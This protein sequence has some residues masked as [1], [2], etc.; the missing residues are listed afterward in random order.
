MVAPKRARRAQYEQG[1]AAYNLGRFDEAASHYQAAY[2]LDRDPIML[3]NAAQSFQVGGRHEQA[4]A[5]FRSYLREAP[6]ESPTRRAAEQAIE[7]LRRKVE[8][9]PVPAAAPTPVVVPAPAPAYVPAPTPLE[10]TPLCAPVPAPETSATP[11]GLVGQPN[12]PSN[13]AEGSPFYKTWW[14]WTAVGAAVVAGSVTAFLLTRQ[15]SN[16]CDGV[17]MECVRVK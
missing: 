3:F 8:A 1:T 13:Q 4:L 17:G 9:S 6:A 7:E 15:T 5:Y 14:F 12:Q 2:D 10:Q 11:G 16:P